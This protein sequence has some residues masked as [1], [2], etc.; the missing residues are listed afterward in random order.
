MS[1]LRRSLR[2]MTAARPCEVLVTHQHNA[3]AGGEPD[4]LDIAVARRLRHR[5]YLHRTHAP[6]L[7]KLRYTTYSRVAD[8]DFTFQC[9]LQSTVQTPIVG[10]SQDSAELGALVRLT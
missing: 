5:I 4:L 3:R 9:R 1:H 10:C 7:Y 6:Q 2:V 8:T